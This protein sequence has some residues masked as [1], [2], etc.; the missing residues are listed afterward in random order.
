MQTI[1]GNLSDTYTDFSSYFSYFEKIL[2]DIQTD[3]IEECNKITFSHDYFLTHITGLLQKV[4]FPF[5][6][7]LL[8]K[9]PVELSSQDL[10]KL[11]QTFSTFFEGLL[12]NIY[13]YLE[14]DNKE[15][16][17]IKT[18]F[19]TNLDQY[20]QILYSHIVLFFENKAREYIEESSFRLENY[21]QLKVK[22]QDT[23]KKVQ[24]NNSLR[25][26]R[27]DSKVMTFLE[28]YNIAENIVGTVDEE[29]G[30]NTNKHEMSFS[31]VLSENTDEK[32][33]LFLKN[34][35][36]EED[37]S[38][39]PNI[40]VPETTAVPFLK[41]TYYNVSNSLLLTEEIKRLGFL[42]KLLNSKALSFIEEIEGVKSLNSFIPSRISSSLLKFWDK[43]SP[44]FEY[45]V[46]LQ[47]RFAVE[48]NFVIP[49]IKS[50]L[51]FADNI[52]EKVSSSLF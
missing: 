48:K 22:Y 34:Q 10:T 44:C 14:P 6:K 32:N 36:T 28:D 1:T 9:W 24:S 20:N 51:S 13:D 3:F 2:P 7:T 52:Q 40:F 43:V 30:S 37:K 49:A 45:F 39:K 21:A 29:D 4:Y 11:M 15:E 33:L 8:G 16:L 42:T 25:N 18:V 46:R 23:N 35:N 17:R 12:S 19:E 47:A 5:L 27:L 26:I 31:K 38:P 41:L 50:L